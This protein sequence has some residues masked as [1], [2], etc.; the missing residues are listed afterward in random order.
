MPPATKTQKQ[1]DDYEEET[2]GCCNTGFMA[3]PGG[4]AIR[5]L[6]VTTAL[7][8]FLLGLALMGDAF[9]ALAGDSAGS[10]F[11]NVNTPIA[12]LQV[13]MLSPDES[14]VASCARVFCCT[15]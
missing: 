5:V 6:G 8:A 9:K 10:M 7:Y 2:Q 15:P 13:I 14:P 12:G 1:N 11:E 3:G 4:T